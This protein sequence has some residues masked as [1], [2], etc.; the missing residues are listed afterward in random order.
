MFL[1]AGPRRTCESVLGSALKRSKERSLAPKGSGACLRV[2]RGGG[3]G[4]VR[5][6][7]RVHC[8]LPPPSQSQ[9][10]TRSLSVVAVLRGWL[11]STRGPCRCTW[12]SLV[13]GACRRSRLARGQASDRRAVVRAAARVVRRQEQPGAAF[14]SGRGQVGCAAA[15]AGHV[16][17]AVECRSAPISVH[18]SSPLLP[19]ERETVGVDQHGKT[20]G[21]GG[22]TARRQRR[23]LSHVMAMPQKGMVVRAPGTPWGRAGCP[24]HIEHSCG[25]FCQWA[26]RNLLI[27]TKSNSNGWASTCLIS[28]A[29]GATTSCAG[30]DGSSGRVGAARS[31]AAR[32]P[33]I[34]GPSGPR[35]RR[36]SASLARGAPPSVPG[37]G[38]ECLTDR[39]AAGIRYGRLGRSEGSDATSR[40]P[41]GNLHLWSRPLTRSRWIITF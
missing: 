24:M 8:R 10:S 16:R 9:S 28:R 27:D 36:A 3:R 13:A 14:C 7:G 33:G 1:S 40:W 11:R 35:S 30:S 31:A 32:H 23:A 34:Q 37:G 21:G 6:Q 20:A 18:R 25:F 15:C 2:L 22:T 17:P 29:A 26:M 5:Y 39:P 38:R 41:R 19:A 4:L 12:V